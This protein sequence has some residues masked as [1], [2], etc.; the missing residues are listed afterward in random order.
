M[1]RR[2]FISLIPLTSFGIGLNIKR[3]IGRAVE[4]TELSR[5]DGS[6]GENRGIILPPALHKGSRIAITAPASPTNAWEIR[7]SVKEL[8]N[9]GFKIEIGDTIHKRQSKYK[10]LSA[11]DEERAVE[12]M[13]YVENPDID[14]I[15]CGRGGYGITRILPKINFE[16]IRQNPKIIIGFSDITILLN[17][18]FSLS[19]VVTF[20]GPVAASTFDKFTI[21]YFK[22]VLMEKE[23]NEELL[24][25]YGTIE[26]INKGVTQG[27]LVGGNLTMLVNSLGTPYEFDAKDSI[28]LVEEYE[29]HPYRIDRMLTQLW[30]AGKLQEANA[31]AVGYFDRI[32]SKRPFYPGG[33]FTIRQVLIDR[34]KP[35][36]KP[37]IIGLP[38]GHIKNKLTLPI[39]INAELDATSRSLILK[40]PSVKSKA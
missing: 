32:D 29:E 36:E 27:R 10:Y 35:L 33:S 31:I 16:R 26:T 38:I 21:E 22:K 18:V 14:C 34:L 37:V 15:L 9:L 8:K 1:N 39:G 40:E 12:F 23:F 30:L 7:H 20:H 19:G 24:I 28:L 13:N 6:T 17:A 4:D 11:S 5:E 25:R 2:N 3:L